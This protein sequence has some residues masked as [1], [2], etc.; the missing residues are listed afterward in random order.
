M[1]DEAVC[2]TA[3]ATPGLLIRIKNISN[4]PNP[5]SK[6]FKVFPPPPFD[7]NTWYITNIYYTWLDL[8]SP[9][10][11]IFP[12]SI[13]YL[14]G[15]LTS[16]WRWLLMK[17]DWVWQNLH[18]SSHYWLLPDRSC[19]MPLNLF[20]PGSFSKLTCSWCHTCWPQWPAP[21]GSWPLWRPWRRSPR[22][23]W[24]RWSQAAQGPGPAA[25]NAQ[26]SYRRL[27]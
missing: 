23:C 6:D 14:Q 20:S 8:D 27:T 17:M 26:S 19:E 12:S 18:L 1:S 22:A 16:L 2:R 13:E 5:Q 24:R 4:W 11:E 3:P 7:T 25:R 9:V 21:C 15:H 10:N